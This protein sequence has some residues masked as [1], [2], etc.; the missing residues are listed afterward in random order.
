M[1]AS[2]ALRRTR[3]TLDDLPQVFLGAEAVRRGWLTP[4]QLRGPLVQR[5]L[6]GAYAAAE[7][8]RTHALRCAAAGLLVPPG[9]MLTG[10]SLATVRGCGLLRTDDDVEVVLAES[11]FRSRV[12]GI[13]QRR[14]VVPLA[15][16]AGFWGDLPTADPARMAFDLAVGRPLAQAVARLDA[17]A[18]AGLVDVRVLREA[19][20]QHRERGVVAVRRAL[21]LADGRAASPPE[22][23]LR[24]LLAVAGVA[25][26]PQVVVR[27]VD[28]AFVARVDLAVD[29]TRVAVEYDGAWHGLASQ[30]DRDRA[31]LNALQDAGWTVVHVTAE[32]MRDPA[33]VVAAVRRAVAR[34]AR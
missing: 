15:P 33:G 12:R 29:G 3:S 1:T 10:A 28:G 6:P 30:V 8:P 18:H 19:L 4:D 17:A 7:R 14:V 16:P 13:R 2:T 21:E 5:L 31:R 26:T 32:M 9:A 27:T 24:L 11:A 34:A 20:A 25:V 23:E 22:S